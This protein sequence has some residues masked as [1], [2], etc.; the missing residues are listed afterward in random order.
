MWGIE[1]SYAMP[2]SASVAAQG[3]SG[4]PFV[5]AQPQSE[6]AKL[7]GEL[8]D[9]VVKEVCTCMSHLLSRVSVYSWHSL[10]PQVRRNLLCVRVYRSSQ[11]RI[12]TLV[13]E[14]KLGLMRSNLG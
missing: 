5:V 7:F 2:L 11:S 1:N 3:D 6:V 8:A 10:R 13:D 4:V 14:V 9:A 12:A